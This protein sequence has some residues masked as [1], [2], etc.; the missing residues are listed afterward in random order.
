MAREVV[1]EWYRS[2]D[3]IFLYISA[4]FKFFL[5]DPSI[6]TLTILLCPS[7]HLHEH[8]LSPPALSLSPFAPSLIY[9]REYKMRNTAP[10]PHCMSSTVVFTLCV[11]P[12]CLKSF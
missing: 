4:D 1:Y 3:L 11:C 9:R 5:K 12:V 8:P 6:C 10:P 2:I 7:I